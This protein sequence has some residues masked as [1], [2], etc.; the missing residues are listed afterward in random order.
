[1]M[2]LENL[3][4]AFYDQPKLVERMMEQR[5][6]AIIAI[7]A[8]VLRHSR[9]ETFWFWED[10][11]HNGG[12]LIDPRLFRRFALPHYQRVC[13][14]LRAQGIQHIWLDSDGDIQRADPA[15]AG[16]GASPGCGRSRLTREWMSSTCAR[17]LRARAGH[18]WG[19]QQICR[20]PGRRDHAPGGGP[21]HAAG[22]RTEAICPSSIT[23]PARHLVEF[24]SVGTWN[25]YCTAWEEVK[26]C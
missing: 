19:D 8:Q 2:G 13:D 9:F 1:M 23:R 7:T 4:L 24:T 10:M 5:T 17:T 25:I 14:W 12:S 15:L 22:R 16:G 3:C 26:N 18:R 20:G 6:E 21:R 11:A